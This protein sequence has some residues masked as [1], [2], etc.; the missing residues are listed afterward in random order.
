MTMPMLALLLLLNLLLVVMVVPPLLV[1]VRRT[2]KTALCT[3]A[4]AATATAIRHRC[5]NTII[6]PF[7][8]RR[9]TLDGW[10]VSGARRC[11][12]AL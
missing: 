5:Y 4:K 1:V 10:N 2:T 6:R 11:V 9:Y 3:A 8:R 7:R 12:S